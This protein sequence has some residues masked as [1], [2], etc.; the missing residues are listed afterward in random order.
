M[1]DTSKTPR[2][3]ASRNILFVLALAVVLLLFF[4][5]RSC[6][7]SHPARGTI[8]PAAVTKTIDGS[9]WSLAEHRGKVVLIDFWATWCPPCRAAM[10]HM[11]KIYAGFNDNPDFL[12]VGVSLD[13]DRGDLEDYLKREQIGWTQLHQ[14]GGGNALANAFGVRAIPSIFIIGRDGRVAGVDLRDH[15]KIREI[16]D[17]ELSK[18]PPSA[19]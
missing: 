13:R 15:R 10:P 8:P 11:K 14:P 1:N 17:A 2:R 18:Q 9:D 4:Q 16:V 7:T 19:Q 6:R 12:M 5:A 3:P